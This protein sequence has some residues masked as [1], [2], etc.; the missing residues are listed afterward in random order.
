[1]G[2]E[3]LTS[4]HLDLISGC[5]I[6]VGGQRQLALFDKLEK[7][8]IPVKGAIEDLAAVLKVKMT[9]HRIVVLASGDPMFHGIG[10]SL[11]RHLTESEFEVHP[12]I[13]TICAAF[14]AIKESWH[15]VKIVSLHG[16]QNPQFIFSTL[17]K[18]NK[19]AFLTDKN[20]DPHFISREMMDAQM[21]D[22]KL[23]VLENLGDPEK[24]KITWFENIDL[25][26]GQT[27]SHPNIVILK[28]L[29]KTTP[30]AVPETHI[31][32]DDFLFAHTDGLITKS[33]IRSITLSK[34]KLMRKDHVVWDIGAGSGSV[35]IEASFQIPWGRVYAIEKNAARISTIIRNIQN[36]NCSNVTV[37]HADFPEGIDDLKQPDRIFIGGG[38][39][40]LAQMLPKACERLSNF[41]VIVINTVL[42]QNIEA[43]V[44]TLKS[45]GF[46]LNI[47]QAQVSR[48]KT[49]PYGDRME[50]LNPIWIIS[51]AKPGHKDKQDEPS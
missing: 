28:K 5:D 1:M 23:C 31:G 34:L 16:K 41:G 32:M 4:K 42:I 40:Q 45:Y 46:N 47:C 26:S 50:A 48:S 8:T 13:N 2:K 10:S 14:A 38:G 24:Q 6:L 3:D 7:Q 21:F 18:E 12:N 30:K 44:H 43:A 25:V 36:F 9:D 22:Y 37:T 33:E 19:I 51:G 49:M 27:F 20:R 29:R 39:E 15:D 35:G 17:S 11:S